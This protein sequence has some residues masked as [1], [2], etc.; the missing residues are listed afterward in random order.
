MSI[1]A[2]SSCKKPLLQIKILTEVQVEAYSQYV[3]PKG[4]LESMNGQWKAVREHLCEDC[5]TKLVSAIQSL[6]LDKK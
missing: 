6:H 5:F 4:E 3:T 1:D 2:C